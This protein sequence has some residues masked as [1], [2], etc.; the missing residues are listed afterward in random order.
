[1]DYVSALKVK[2][3]LSLGVKNTTPDFRPTIKGGNIRGIFTASGTDLVEQ[4]VGGTTNRTFTFRA[5]FFSQMLAK[6]GKIDEVY[7]LGSRVKSVRC[8]PLQVQPGEYSTTGISR[9]WLYTRGDEFNRARLGRVDALGGDIDKSM[10]QVRDA[11]KRISTREGRVPG[12]GGHIYDSLVICGTVGD[13]TVNTPPSLNVDEEWT[14]FLGDKIDEAVEATDR[15]IGDKL[16][17]GLE[18]FDA[19]A[20]SSY[21]FDTSTWFAVPARTNF[22]AQSSRAGFFIIPIT[23]TD[24]GRPPGFQRVKVRYSCYSNVRPIVTADVVHITA[25]LGDQ[26]KIATYCTDANN[27]YVQF[28]YE[29]SNEAAFDSVEYDTANYFASYVPNE[30]KAYCVRDG[31]FD[32]MFS[33]TDSGQP[34]APALTPTVVHVSVASVSGVPRRPAAQ[35]GPVVV[36]PQDGITDDDTGWLWWWFLEGHFR[37]EFGKLQADRAMHRVTVKTGVPPSRMKG[38]G[39][40][41]NTYDC[42]FE[43]HQ[44]IPVRMLD[45]GFKDVL[46]DPAHSNVFVPGYR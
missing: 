19:T 28:N 43:S 18:R 41:E 35:A 7:L 2:K 13:V 10:L 20:F 16:Q 40:T 24:D 22:V 23:V 5:G 46:A 4:A 9:L 33:G 17:F 11:I 8:L 15:D 31:E 14:Y 39:T 42:V 44:V 6:G 34:P 1:V 21:A 26:I 27:D 45:N 25:N 12:M 37:G 36:P 30:F 32:I 38:I 3:I 29:L